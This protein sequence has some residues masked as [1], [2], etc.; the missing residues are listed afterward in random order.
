[1]YAA[2]RESCRQSLCDVTAFV[3]DGSGERASQD[4]CRIAIIYKCMEDKICIVAD[5]LQDIHELI[6]CFCIDGQ[7]VVAA[8]VESGAFY[9]VSLLVGQGI[10]HEDIL[11][12]C[13]HV[14]IIPGVFKYPVVVVVGDIEYPCIPWHGKKRK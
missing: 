2:V 9:C 7:N 8:I 5:L 3:C 14:A 13:G 10:P 4:N 1:M 11:E 6:C 12:C